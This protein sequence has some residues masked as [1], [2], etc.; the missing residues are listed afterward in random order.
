MDT[1]PINRMPIHQF[2][3]SCTSSRYCRHL[4][5]LL[6]PFAKRSRQERP[7]GSLPAFAWDDVAASRNPY[8]GDYRLAFACSIVLYPLAHHAGLAATLP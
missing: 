8:P 7:D 4:L 3:G 6:C 1:L 2:A 5:C